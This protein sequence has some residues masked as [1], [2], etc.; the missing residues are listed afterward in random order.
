MRFKHCLQ[1]GIRL[2]Q[3][4]GALVRRFALILGAGMLVAAPVLALETVTLQL[5]WSH[6]FQFAG[7]YAAIEKGYYREAGLDV[8]LRE[9]AP[10]I[11]PLEAVLTGK[12]QYGV[13]MSN[14]LLA[15]HAGRP[16]VVLAVIFQHSPMVLIARRQ[17]ADGA[18]PVVQ[19][20]AGRRVM[21]EPQSDELIAYLRQEG[22]PLERLT[23]LPHSHRLDDF[24]AGR[25]DAMSAYVTSEPYYLD[26]A[27]F[28]YQT[29]SPVMAGIDFYGDNLFTTES[30]LKTHPERARAFR[31]ASLRGWQYAMAHPEEIADLIRDKYSTRHPRDFYLF[32]ARKMAPLLRIDLVE[33]GHMTR[34][35]WRHIA[36]T[37]AQFGLLPA[38]APLDGFL[39]EPDAEYDRRPIYA[40]FGLL[41]AV[42]AVTWYYTILNRRLTRALAAKTRAEAEVRRLIYQDPLTGLPNRRL[43]DDRFGHL[44]AWLKRDGGNGAAIHLMVSGSTATD[45]R[46]VPALVDQWLP[47]VAGRLTERLR[48]S[49]TVARLEGADFLVLLGALDAG[50]PTAAEQ[51][52]AV[53][54]EL[55]AR[56]VV[57]Y[58]LPGEG[59]T[60]VTEVHCTASLGVAL[61]DGATEGVDAL[62]EAKAAMLRA[63]AGGPNRIEVAGHP[64][65]EI[66]P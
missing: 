50:P 6:A 11:D 43:L 65:A 53:A 61:F 21:I 10:G 33:P 27:G 12:A 59:D 60:G 25:V 20:L 8:N 63:R 17:P 22:I 2:I 54:R 45:E 62:H 5:K 35:R 56:V 37:Y 1:A 38:A 57:P 36:D 66:E 42:F 9:A 16:V 64:A 4:M 51:A 26:R 14:L 44:L 58:R 3:R 24:I 32:E 34:G 23:R 39:Y 47:A 40:L 46:L 18:V 31:E 55:L 48:G 29:Y 15:R 52:S 30:E 13:G 19:N 28:S 49:D 41:L 7:Y